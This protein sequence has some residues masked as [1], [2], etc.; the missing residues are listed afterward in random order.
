MEDSE[1]FFQTLGGKGK[2]GNRER[3]GQGYRDCWED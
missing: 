2:A 3:G 1:S